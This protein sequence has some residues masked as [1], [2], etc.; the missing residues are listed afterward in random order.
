[1]KKTFEVMIFLRRC[2]TYQG[3]N[4]STG[5]EDGPEP[6][7]VTTLA[8][9]GRVR[10]HDGALCRPEQ[11]SANTEESTSK[12]NKAHV[13][14]VGVAEKRGAV[15]AVAETANG[16]GQA[17]SKTV[18]KSASEETD[19][20]KSAVESCV[21]VVLSRGF[22]LTSSSKTAQGI[23]HSRA[24]EADKGHHEK[25]HLGRC[26]PNLLAAEREAPVHPSCRAIGQDVVLRVVDL[27]WVLGNSPCW[28][29]FVTHNFLGR[30]HV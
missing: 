25:L 2:N 7:D 23:E 1:M 6:R 3:A 5:V 19:D 20:G 22:D 10:H 17:N 11:T 4:D 14:R 26:V 8:V 28:F 29:L 9:L 16:Q 15:D 13:L 12:D 21:G 27:V 24:Q 30:L 18:S